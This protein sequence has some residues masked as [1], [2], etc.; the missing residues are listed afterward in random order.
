MMDDLSNSIN[1]PVDSFDFKS[2]ISSVDSLNRDEVSN[3]FQSIDTKFDKETETIKVESWIEWAKRLKYLKLINTD[4]LDWILPKN[5]S[6]ELID[7]K[8]F[9][10]RG[11]DDSIYDTY[12]LVRD[13]FARGNC[14]LRIT[15]G[16]NKG[17]R[18][19][20]Y[21]LKKFTGGLGDDDDRDKGDNVTWKKYFIKPLDAA[22]R[23]VATRKANG[24]AQ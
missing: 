5:C 17:S 13:G 19:I 11:P 23:V 14:F 16:P 22:K 20:L 2:S 6:G 10:A 1:D 24:E 8:V 9:C 21:A 18:C 4:V 15:R 7:A 3:Y 12:T